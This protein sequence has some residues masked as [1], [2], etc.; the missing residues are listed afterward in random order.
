MVKR[1]RSWGKTRSAKRRRV[2]RRRLIR[3]RV[4]TRRNVLQ[5]KR[6][7]YKQTFAGSDVTPGIT[8]ATTFSLSDVPA[9][10]EFTP[11]FEEY[12]IAG[13]AYRWVL[14]REPDFATGATTKGNSVRVMHVADHTDTAL[15]ANF[16]ELQQYPRVKEDWL[17]DS[18]MASRWYWLK[19]NTIDVGYTSGVAS[20]YGV[21]YR[22]WIDTSNTSTP[23]YGLKMVYDAL[24]AGIGLFLECKYYLKF[25]GAK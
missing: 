3:R 7:V 21:N 20:N 16:A 10:A 6:F 9:F 25:K 18:K 1:T 15:P 5:T 23:Y 14:N 22:R 24:Y 4:V 11:L 2:T 13:I 17:N 12:Q 8:Y 19:P